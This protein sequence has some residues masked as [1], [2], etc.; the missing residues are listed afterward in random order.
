M[1]ALVLVAMGVGAC[2]FDWMRYGRFGVVTGLAWGTACTAWIAIRNSPPG[3]VAYWQQGAWG[4]EFTA[5][6]LAQLPK[7]EWQVLHD[8]ADH[9]GN[10]DHVVAGPAG[11]FLLD[12]KKYEGMVSVEGD[13]LIV[14]R[15][16][17]PSHSYRDR[18]RLGVIRAQ[19]ARLNRQLRDRSGRSA[20]VEPVV[21]IWGGF[22]ARIHKG[23]GVTV[24]HGRELTTW[25]RAQPPRRVNAAGLI[26]YLRQGRHR[27]DRAVSV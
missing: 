21:V 27:R 12:S 14:T 24:V 16:I 15:A 18:G 5:D 26:Q 3:F 2:A 9:G 6:E 19:A 7:R 10:I 8:L 11:I 20:W 4:E 23:N 13:D 22:P 1:V 17:D 25:L